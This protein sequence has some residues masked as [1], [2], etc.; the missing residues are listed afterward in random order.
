MVVIQ[1][2]S[3]LYGKGAFM[4]SKIIIGLILFLIFLFCFSSGISLA[5]DPG[6]ADTVRLAS[7]SGEIGNTASMPVFLY[8][9]EELTKV[10]IPLLV[11]GYSGW[12][13]FDSVSYMDSR[14]SDP[15]ILD[16]RQVYVFGTDIFTVDSL[17]LSF[18]VSSGNNLPVGAGKLCDLWFTLHFG[19]AVLVDSLPVSPQGGLSLTTTG[20]QSFTPQFSSGLI[21]IACNYLVGDVTRDDR[22]DVSDIIMHQKFYFYDSPWWDYPIF[23]RAGRFD[24]NCD[25]RLDMRD[26]VHLW[27]Y[28]F[29]QGSKP[30]TCGTVNP[31]FYDD[32][33][34]PDT[35]W[36]KSETL[37]VGISS[38]VCIGIINDEIL[39][40]I[41]LALEWDGSAVM[42]IDWESGP[43]WTDRIDSLDYWTFLDQDHANGV[44]PD[45]FLFYG[46]P[47][48]YSS[49]PFSPGREAVVCPR[50]IPQSAGT[51][52][53][54]LVSWINGS[55]SMLVTEDRAAILPV[56]YGGN[57]TV[58]PY[59][60]GDPNHDGIINTSDV[61]Y[62]I[63][64][65]FIGGPQ[66]IPLESGDAT[67]EGDV[68][69][70]DVI[71]L[72]NYLFV[73]GPPPSC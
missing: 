25:R 9:D 17:L 20:P 1:N 31:P 5:Q 39:F 71:Y 10:V 41:A 38:P 22:I 13:R 33:G 47:S 70:S 73:G 7:I 19:G 56:F 51:A 29:S 11:D 37:I 48:S 26:L 61:V 14:L 28:I 65:L 46:W 6:V 59:L 50:F 34:L 63:N 53:F 4:R 12:L 72:I 66:P 35:V 30:C 2:Y 52:T 24:L 42:E 62:L 57:L 32:P 69:V 67:C 8:N 15:I 40:G 49:T 45:T 27:D 55:E 58:L 36:V 44:N 16:A 54:R 23:E 3:T 60:A 64:Y 68:N 18:S 21:D 43:F